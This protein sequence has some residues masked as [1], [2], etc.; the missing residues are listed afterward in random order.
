MKQFKEEKVTEPIPV[1]KAKGRDPIK[2]YVDGLNNI[3]SCVVDKTKEIV[4]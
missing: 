2:S 3:E 1:P 4:L